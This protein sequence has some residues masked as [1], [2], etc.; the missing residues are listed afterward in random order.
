MENLVGGMWV[1]LILKQEFQK[2]WLLRCFKIFS[3]SGGLWSLNCYKLSELSYPWSTDLS[4]L[5]DI[6]TAH[7]PLRTNHSNLNQ[8]TSNKYSS[9]VLT[10]Q[11]PL[12]LFCCAPFAV[13]F[14][15]CCNSFV[16]SLSQHLDTH[17][18]NPNLMLDD[19]LSAR[20]NAKGTWEISAENPPTQKTRFKD[21]AFLINFLFSFS[22]FSAFVSPCERR[23]MMKV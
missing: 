18:P 11:S 12:R 2:R 5:A 10:F 19:V 9:R 6:I 16:V 14:F 8:S 3:E 21:S 17:A 7:L 13:C 23:W 1:V 20:D 22:S 4:W 15:A